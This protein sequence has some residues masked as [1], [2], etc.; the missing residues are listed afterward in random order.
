[1]STATFIMTTA[2]SYKTTTIEKKD[3]LYTTIGYAANTRLWD[4]GG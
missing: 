3:T 1:M 2:K 4:I